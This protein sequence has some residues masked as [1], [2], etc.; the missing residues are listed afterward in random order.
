[1]LLVPLPPIAGITRGLDFLHSLQHH[2]DL[3][4]LKDARDSVFFGDGLRSVAFWDVDRLPFA[5]ADLWEDHALP[6]ANERAYPV[7]MHADP[8]K[9][10][11]RPS[12]DTLA[13]FE[14][15]MRALAVTAEDE[16]DTGR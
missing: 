15:L 16:I 8:S 4:D 11:R 14:G 10:L 2:W 9:R 12:A 7:A 3:Y 6:L 13:F 5:D 1:M